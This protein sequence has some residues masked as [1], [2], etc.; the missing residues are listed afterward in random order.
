MSPSDLS[1][2]DRVCYK[3]YKGCPEDVGVI[4]AEEGALIVVWAARKAED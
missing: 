1:P 3:G 2:G 4:I